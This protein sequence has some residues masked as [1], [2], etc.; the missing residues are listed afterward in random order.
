[1]VWDTPQKLGP[2]MPRRLNKSTAGYKTTTLNHKINRGDQE[3]FPK[4]LPKAEGHYRVT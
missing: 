3:L 2:Q 1:M 4:M